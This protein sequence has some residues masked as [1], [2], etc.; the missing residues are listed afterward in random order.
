[1]ICLLVIPDALQ[2]A[3]LLRRSGT[4]VY[5]RCEPRISTAPLRAAVHPG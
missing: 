5:L 1:M 2:H 4:F 3:V